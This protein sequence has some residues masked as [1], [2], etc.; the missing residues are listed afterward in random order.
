MTI[1]ERND[2]FYERLELL[3]KISKKSFNQIEKDLGY[4]RNALANYK[5]GTGV[6]GI[7]LVELAN[8]FEVSPEYLLGVGDLDSTLMVNEIFEKL[9]HKHKKQMFILCE[10]WILTQLK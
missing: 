7:R 6:S 4:P 2:S 9:D 5:N 10:K 8:Y 3:K 1:D